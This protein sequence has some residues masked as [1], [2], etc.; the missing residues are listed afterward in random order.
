M[1][2]LALCHNSVMLYIGNAGQNYNLCNA[3]T[4]HINAAN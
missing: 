4:E 2:L 1:L 3:F